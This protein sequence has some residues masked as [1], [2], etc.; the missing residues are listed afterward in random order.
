MLRAAVLTGLMAL[1]AGLQAFGGGLPG[2]PL[3]D[4]ALRETFENKQ[5]EGQRGPIRL[6]ASFHSDGT[7][8]L[9]GPLG[10]FDGVWRVWNG[11]VCLLMDGGPR[12]GMHCSSVARLDAGALMTD[13]GVVLNRRASILRL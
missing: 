1:G 5:F 12:K 13:R 11:Q 2:A 3:Q 9:Q 7:L 8:T 4:S 10:Q 6:L